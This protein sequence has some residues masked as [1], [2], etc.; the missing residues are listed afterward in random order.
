MSDMPMNGSDDTEEQVARYDD[1]LAAAR[2]AMNDLT[3]VLNP[4]QA[5]WV[6][7]AIREANQRYTRHR[8]E[9]NTKFFRDLY[10]RA[11]NNTD[12]VIVMLERYFG[13]EA[14]A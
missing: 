12:E 5:M 8:N 9:S 14:H 2:L 13:G 11:I 3:L 6:N 7:A 1:E 10:Q 4:N